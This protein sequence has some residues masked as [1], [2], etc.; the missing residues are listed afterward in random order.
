V[1]TYEGFSGQKSFTKVMA[2]YGHETLTIDASFEFRPDICK[3]ILT[4]EASEFPFQVDMAWFSPPCEGFSVAAIGRNWNHDHTPKTDSARMGIALLTKALDLILETDPT[5]WFIENPRG[6][7]RRM[8]LMYDPEIGHHPENHPVMRDNLVRRHTVTYCQYGDTRMKPTDI[9][10]N[11][12][13]WTP[14]PICKNGDKCHEAA[15]RGSKTGTQGLKG[16]MARGVIPPA[17]F[18][19]ILEQ[20]KVDDIARRDIV[21]SDPEILRRAA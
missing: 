18:E 17:L 10:T 19:E 7:M 4:M 15:P 21:S 1:T 2:R 16:A 5:W 8:P 3:N 6:K 20:K 13:W 12:Y 9:W 11:A 14:R